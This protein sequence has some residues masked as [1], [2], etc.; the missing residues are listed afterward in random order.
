MLLYH[1]KHGAELTVGVRKYEVKVPFGVVECDDVRIKQLR[2]KPSLTLFINAGIY[3]LEPSV[4]D[5]IPDG[6]HFDMTDLIQKLLDVG[7]TVVSF[8]IM[9]YW[10]D[11]GRHEDYQQAQEDVRNGRI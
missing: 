11:V 10:L 1:R 4:C 2:E 9:E 3:L 8:P 7:R 5:Y 6:E